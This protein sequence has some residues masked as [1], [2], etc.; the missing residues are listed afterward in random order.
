MV[1]ENLGIDCSKSI[2]LHALADLLQKNF[3]EHYVR[4]VGIAHKRNTYP[5]PAAEI[6]GYM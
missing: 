4:T 2:L 6:C 3:S 5:S 1:T